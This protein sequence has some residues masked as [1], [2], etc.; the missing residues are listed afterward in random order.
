MLLPFVWVRYC[1]LTRGLPP[2]SGRSHSSSIILSPALP[3]SRPRLSSWRY[4]YLPMD[5]SVDGLQEM[6]TCPVWPVAV[7]PVGAAGGAGILTDDTLEAGL[8]STWLSE[9]ILKP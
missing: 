3:T 2:V 5:V 1:H 7:K 8:A 9:R 4:W 6:S